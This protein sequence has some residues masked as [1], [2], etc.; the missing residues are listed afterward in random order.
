MTV[1]WRFLNAEFS[2]WETKD[3][4]FNLA[5]ESER[6]QNFEAAGLTLGIGMLSFP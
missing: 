5:W 6:F 4:M 1:S 3:I 2:E